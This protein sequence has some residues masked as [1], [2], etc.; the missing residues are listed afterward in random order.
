[1]ASNR[2]DRIEQFYLDVILER[3]WGFRAGVVR[4]FL[5]ALSGLYRLIVT[6]RLW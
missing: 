2:F 3:S 4:L 1:M 6:G 5:W